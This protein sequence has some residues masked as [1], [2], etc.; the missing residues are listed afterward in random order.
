VSLTYRTYL[1]MPYILIVEDDEDDR[2]LFCSAVYE[3]DPSIRCILAR[4][5]EEALLGLR[6]KEFPRPNLI[7]L[8]LNMPRINGFQCLKELKKDRLL[9]DIPVAIYS[10]TDVNEYREECKQLGAIHFITKPT[11]LTD[12]CR[13]ISDVMLKEMI[14][15]K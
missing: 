6:L 10:T 2:D 14:L 8:D 7:F 13:V 5:G 11:Q 1:F 12:L 4:N 9:Q 3:I 15:L